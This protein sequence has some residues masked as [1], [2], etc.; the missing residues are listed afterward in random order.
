MVLP[1]R[2]KPGQTALRQLGPETKKKTESAMRHNLR[3][4]GAR[5]KMGKQLVAVQEGPKREIQKEPS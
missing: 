5:K 3:Q 2:F 4:L 1:S